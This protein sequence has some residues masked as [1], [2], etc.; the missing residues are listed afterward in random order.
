MGI[1]AKCWEKTRKKLDF[2][3]DFACDFSFFLIGREYLVGRDF[4][5]FV[6]FWAMQSGADGEGGRRRSGRG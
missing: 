2:I 1:V 5:Q 6:D 3:G 4:V